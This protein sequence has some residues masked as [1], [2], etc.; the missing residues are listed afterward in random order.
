MEPDKKISGSLKIN[1]TNAFS[2]LNAFV[3]AHNMRSEKS[4]DKIKSASLLAAKEIIRIYGAFLLK[5]G[6]VST[7]E[8]TVKD[9]WPPLRTNNEQLAG[10]CKCS[11]RSIQRHIKRL[12]HAGFIVKKIFHGTNASYELWINHR[13]V[14]PPDFC[15]EKEPGS[16]SKTTSKVNEVLSLLPKCPDTD[17]TGYNNI[18]I[19]VD[20]VDNSSK[21]RTREDI[22]ADVT[23][24]G[25]AGHSE[26]GND[27]RVDF[28][29]PELEREKKTDWGG[30]GPASPARIA[31]LNFYASMLWTLA[32]N[33]IYR[34]KFL[35]AEQEAL[36]RN[37]LLKYYETVADE[38]LQRV[39]GIYVERIGLVS[40]Y[41]KKNPEQ[42]YVQL[43]DK[44][45]DLENA[46]GF[47]G[48]KTWWQKQN[49][50]NE[51][52]RKQLILH[53]QL[54][55]Y[56][57]NLKKDTAKRR[58]TLEVFRECEQRLGK[59]HDPDLLQQFHAI[60]LHPETYQQLHKKSTLRKKS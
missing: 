48:T 30:G 34:D 44:Y 12:I 50:R 59:L 57:N 25:V 49:E 40:K 1:F 52:L 55:R 38:K 31:S 24:Y 14:F 37:H 10:I 32:R 15:L 16:N 19:D 42:R 8:G 20:N 26:K 2:A 11:S 6:G 33:T 46:N 41:I 36:A 47:R 7:P 17:F 56:F 27:C 60:I 35:T 54:R 45:F 4:A 23:G 9:R 21:T 29:E 18:I 28:R 39:H 51:E 3:D 53:A 5:A 43:P 58:S 13:I 22:A